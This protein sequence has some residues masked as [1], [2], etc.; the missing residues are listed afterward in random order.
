MSGVG[1]AMAHAGPSTPREALSSSAQARYDQIIETAMTLFDANGFSGT[2]TDDIAGGAGVTKRTLYRYIGNKQNLLFHIYARFLTDETLV[3]MRGIS[4]TPPERLR[5]LMAWHVERV[6]SHRRE[7]R[8]FHEDKKHLSADQR[9]VL[10]PLREEYERIFR[11][12]IAEGQ[13]TGHFRT[14]D[15]A[16]VAQ[17]IIGALTNLY[18]WY[19]I[20]GRVDPHEVSEIVFMLFVGGLRAERVGSTHSRFDDGWIDDLEPVPASRNAE[21]Q[22]DILLA[23]TRLFSQKGFRVS[24]T[25]EL[26]AAANITKGSFFYHVGSKDEVLFLLHQWVTGLGIAAFAAAMDRGFGAAETLSEMIRRFMHIVHRHGEAIAVV[27]E[28]MKFLSPEHKSEVKAARHK[29]TA[30]LRSCVETGVSQGVFRPLDLDITTMLIAGMLNSVHR[31]YRP[32]GRSSPDDLGAELASL[33][34]DG[35]EQRE[36]ATH[37]PA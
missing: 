36:H 18:Q 12:V 22:R 17:G 20:A 15:V 13:A 37:H 24:T 33:V 11:D 9:R 31:W 10:Q 32:D 3:E 26:A 7:V 4:G 29:Y 16:V 35:L 27:T 19:E 30:L 5:Q 6:G 14:C 2:T 23:A 21:V 25:E 34:L 1:Q 8:I 28:E